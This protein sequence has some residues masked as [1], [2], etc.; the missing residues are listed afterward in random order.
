[1]DLIKSYFS[2]SFDLIIYDQELPFDLYVNSSTLSKKQKFIRIFPEGEMF[3]KQDLEDFKKKYPQLYIS[4]EHRKKYMRSLVQSEDTS[5]EKAAEFIKDSAIKYLHNVFD[6][7]KEFSTQV[8]EETIE[9]CKDAVE[10]MIDL[11]D[12][13]S[14]DGLRGLIGNLSG[15]DFYTYD[16]S[17]NVS[18]YSITILR[19]IKPNA[20]RLE[21]TH[22][23]LG[24]LLHDLGKIKI[25]TEIINKPANLTDEEYTVIKTHPDIGIKLLLESEGLGVESI[26]LGTI[27]RVV[28]EHHENW[29][30]GGYPSG[31]QGTDIHILARICAIADFFDAITTKRSYAE[32]VT[33]SQAL[34]IMEKTAGKKI[35]PKIF[36]AFKSHISQSNIIDVKELTIADNFDP[37][38]PHETLPLIEEEIVPKRKGPK[39]VNMFDHKKKG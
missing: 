27:A 17:I 18:M 24:G 23:G 11:L 6:P 34:N 16:H 7:K 2:V 14:I 38:M 30:G 37:C 35:D 21:L 25:P 1:L 19:V 36:Q 31:I 20:T 26:D 8:L 3:T 33:I 13:Y 12:D 32:V 15:H 4:E 9:G 29:G 10:N 39:K 28:H 22:A 5:D